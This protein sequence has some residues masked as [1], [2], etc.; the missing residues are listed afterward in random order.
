MTQPDGVVMPLPNPNGEVGLQ[1]LFD[2]KEG[3]GVLDSKADAG[4]EPATFKP[5]CDFSAQLLL[6]ETGNRS[7]FVGWYNSPATDVAPTTVCDETTGMSSGGGPCTENDIFVLI[8]GDV[9]D[10]PFGKN[11]DPLHHPG[12]IFTGADLAANPLYKGGE[13]GFVLMSSQGHFSEKR[14]NPACTATT[15]VAGDRWIPT[16]IYASKTTPRGYYMCSEDQDVGPTQWGGNDG[17]FNDYVFLFTGLVCSGSGETCDTGQPGIC[18]AGLTDCAD[19]TGESDCRP[20]R[21]PGA[22]SC[23]GLDD[24]CDGDT[25]EGDLCPVG[26]LCVKSRCVPVCGTGEFRCDNE[27][28]CVDGACVEKSCIDVSCEAGKVCKGGQCVG[29]CDDVKCPSGQSCADGVCVDP[30]AGIDCGDGFVCEGG[31]CLVECGC[32]GC[33][34]GECDTTSGH[35][36]PSGCAGKECGDGQHCA[37]GGECVDDCADVR[38]PGGAACTA[39]HCEPPSS[40]SDDEPGATGGADN[41]SD[42]GIS[43]GG[44]GPGSGSGNPQGGT[45]SVGGSTSSGNGSGAVNNGSSGDGSIESKSGCACSAPGGSSSRLGWSVAAVAALLLA[46]RRRRAA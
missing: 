25:D 20:A 1:D 21:T 29:A 12:K 32:A 13:I 15:C 28:Q 23:N 37:G 6:H 10:P 19:A 30:C 4:T 22:E 5:L 27:H 3:A 34:S 46:S 14:L 26:E 40:G 44:E 7:A 24:D 43:F 11:A 35:C 41:G 9:A 8:K 17:D 36:A 16:I 39:G 33:A 38:C 31:A 18:A 2:F 45:K 42:P